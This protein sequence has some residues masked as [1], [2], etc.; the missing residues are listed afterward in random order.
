MQHHLSTE[1]RATVVPTLGGEA[2]DT[3][4]RLCSEL[5]EAIANL[6]AGGDTASGIHQLTASEAWFYDDVADVLTALPGRNV[7]YTPIEQPE[8]AARMRERGLPE[9]MIQFSMNFHSEVRNDLLDEVSPEMEQLLGRRP[10]SLKDGL[11]VLFN[12]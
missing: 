2:H 10:A 4:A 7:A 6:L 8:F 9:R 5:G 3:T 12:L 1:H 11:K